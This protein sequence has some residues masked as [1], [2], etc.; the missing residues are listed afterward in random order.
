MSENA[1]VPNPDAESEADKYVQPKM[2]SLEPKRFNE[3]LLRLVG[4]V[5]MFVNAESFEEGG[6]GYSLKADWYRGKISTIGDD[7]MTIVAEF[8][9]GAGKKAPTEMIKQYIPIDKIKRITKM[10]TDLLIH[11]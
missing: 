1:A 11:L 7:Y 6:F 4:R 9:H 10:K 5:V 3:V 2:P 8:K